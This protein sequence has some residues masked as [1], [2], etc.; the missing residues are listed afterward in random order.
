MP[1]QH[2]GRK[3]LNRDERLWVRI[4][5]HRDEQGEYLWQRLKIWGATAA[6]IAGGVVAFQKIDLAGIVHFLFGF[7]RM[8][9]GQ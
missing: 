4:K 8:L 2:D 7:A 1:V 3:P 9:S 5:K 6:G